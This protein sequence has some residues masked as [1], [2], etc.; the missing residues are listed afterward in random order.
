MSAPDIVPQGSNH[1]FQ[2]SLEGTGLSAFTYTLEAR[3]HPDDTPS[4]N[5]VVTP[6]SSGLVKVTLTPAETANLAIGLW[7]ITIKAE[8]ADETLQNVKRIQITRAWM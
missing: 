4:I 3:Q 5:R 1:D 7:F 8:D 2:F 6:D